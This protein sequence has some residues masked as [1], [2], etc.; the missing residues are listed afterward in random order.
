[1]SRGGRRVADD[2]DGLA[3]TVLARLG[4]VALHLVPELRDGAGLA[5]EH[6]RARA[7]DVAREGVAALAGGNGVDPEMAERREVAVSAVRDEPSE[8]AARD[9]LEEH[10]LHR[11]ERA[12]A[13][14]LVALRLDQGRGHAQEL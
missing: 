7:R 13:E 2:V 10:A 5:D 3:R 8:T 12:E 4:K 14:D 11:V 9:V 6:A 1:M